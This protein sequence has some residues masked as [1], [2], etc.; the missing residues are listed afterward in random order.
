M[1]KLKKKRKMARKAA[2]P[3]Q[4]KWGPL[5]YGSYLGPLRLCLCGSANY[6]DLGRV[7]K[8]FGM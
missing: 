1:S 3:H 6:Q 2:K 4:H 5:I 7:I 8:L